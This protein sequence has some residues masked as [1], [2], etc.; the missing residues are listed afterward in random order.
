MRGP[1]AVGLPLCLIAALL[2]GAAGLWT[3]GRASA[4]TTDKKA[5]EDKKKKKRKPV[6]EYSKY[7]RTRKVDVQL[8]EKRKGIRDQL[9]TLLEYEED[10]KE[11]PALLFRLAENY[12]EEAMAFFN[13]AM[14]LDDDLAKDPTNDGLRKRVEAGKKTLR[15]EEDTWRNQAIDLYKQIV[16]KYPDYPGRDQV[17]FYLGYSLWDMKRCKEALTIYKRL[18]QDYPKSQYIPDA[19]LAFGEFYFEDA[20]LERALIAYKKAA[21]YEEAEIYPYALYKQGWCYFNLHEWGKAKDM[22]QSV[23]LLADMGSGKIEIRK[24]ALNDFTLTYSHDGSAKEAPR[25]FKRLAP[26]ESHVMLINLA[27]MYFGDGQ[28]KKAIILYR[29]LIGEEKCSAEVPFYQGRIVDAASRV[30]DKRYV[31]NQTRKLV[32]LFQKVKQCVKKPD[33]KQKNRIK[34]AQELA[35]VTL[36]KLASIWYKE[37]KETKQKDTFLY[38]Q[39]MFGDYLELFPDS[40]DAYDMRFAY[41]E[42]LFHRLN[43][44]DRAAVEYGKI[45]ASDLAYKKQ[46]GKFPPKEKDPKK[47]A[48]PGTYLCDAAFKSMQAHRE[49]MKK[50]RRMDKSKRRKKDKRKKDEKD[51]KKGKQASLPIPKFKR[52]FIKAAELYM[53]NCPTDQ[54]ILDVKYDIAKTYY[55]YFHVDEAVRRFDEIVRDFPDKELTVYAANLVLDALSESGDF[56]RLNTYARKYYKNQKLMQNERLRTDL[57][58]LIPNIA[59]KRIE[60]LD[61][62]LRTPPKGAKPMPEQRIHSKV[63]YAFVKFWRE[64]PKHELADEALFNASVKYELAERLDKARKA[65]QLLIDEYPKSDLVPGTIFNL[66]ENYERMADFDSAAG[67]YERYAETYKRMAGLGKAVTYK[68]RKKK[69]GRRGGRAKKKKPAKKEKRFEGNRRTWNMEDAQAALLNAGIYREA[70]RQYAKA[71]KDRLEYVDLFPSSPETPQVYYSLALLYEARGQHA[72]AA[73][74]FDNYASRYLSKNTDRAIAA[75]MKRAEMLRKT[76]RPKW[77]QISSEIQKTLSLYLKYKRKKV[78]LIEA[79]EAAAHAA[80]ITAEPDYAEYIKYRFTQARQKS[81]K[82][83]AEHFKRQLDEKQKRL[84]KVVKVYEAVAKRKQPEWTI[85]SLYKLGRAYENMAETY[86]KAPLPKGLTPEQKDIYMTM[87][88]EKGQPWEDKAVVHF[89]AAVDKGSE[90][91]Y[92]SRFTQQALKKLQ[93]YRPAEYPREELGFA[94]SVVT[95]EAS[96][97]PLLLAL[98]D[99]AKKEP[100]LLD[101]PPLATQRVGGEK[102]SP[103]PEKVS[104]PPEKVSPPPEK[105]GVEP[106]EG[107]KLGAGAGA[108]GQA[109]PG[110]QAG[111]AK[112]AGAKTEAEGTDKPKPI[113]EPP[114][115]VESAME[116][117]PEDEFD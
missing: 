82:A 19:Y 40:K 49:I 63:A 52:R 83:V 116:E 77:S 51:K 47:R 2:V 69:K 45:V 102:A 44:F 46:H 8:A 108:G 84:K 17:L 71:V 58:R 95:D 109:G 85:A 11:K 86:Y 103:P 110:G 66:A 7:R 88:R 73:E 53:D 100:K 96:R 33:E 90:L 56:E 27:S 80:F 117:E 18:I 41:A 101:E 68:D 61:K 87:L 64:F 55:D 57:S 81:Q 72:K 6:L 99:K 1:R 114:D 20:K 48:A 9:K 105:A 76:K 36:R 74:I 43:R 34:E 21:E 60:G 79:A 50:S 32:E 25:I 70:L 39:E 91:G 16:N 113:A 67:L 75:H 54:D 14:E 93:H 13:Q 106:G 22:F 4:F 30:G 12:T 89:K 112:S 111:G 104:P 35:E 38:S 23:I 31:V 78:K 94:L 59:F 24:E 107:A 26:K 29:Y 115:P 5:E 3:A 92:Y 97:G 28:D 65:R 42:L 37:A 62:V 98:W 10:P 15:K